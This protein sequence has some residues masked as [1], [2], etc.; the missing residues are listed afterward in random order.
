MLIVYCIIYDIIVLGSS[1]SCMKQSAPDA[2]FRNEDCRHFNY[3]V[4]ELNANVNAA[5]D[6]PDEGNI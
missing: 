4:C 6:E 5:F 2:H 3:F 1:T